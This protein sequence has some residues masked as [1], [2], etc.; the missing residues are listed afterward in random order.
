MPRRANKSDIERALIAAGFIFIA[1]SGRGG[2]E[3]WRSVSGL[4]MVMVP[5]HRGYLP[6]GTFA[7]IRRQAGGWSTAKFWW[8]ADGQ[9]G[10]EPA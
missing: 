9:R 10:T 6:S 2:H 4:E 3:K 7:N 5:R 8:Y 1:G